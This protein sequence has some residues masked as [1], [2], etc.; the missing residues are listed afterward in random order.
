M[1]FHI[2]IYIQQA[3]LRNMEVHKHQGGLPCKLQNQSL[4]LNEYTGSIS[5]DVEV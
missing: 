2:Y 4:L 5:F 1:V 3:T